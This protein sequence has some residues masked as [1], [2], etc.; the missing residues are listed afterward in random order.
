MGTPTSLNPRKLIFEKLVRLGTLGGRSKMLNL[1][2]ACCKVYISESRNKAALEMIERAAKLFPKARIINKFEDDTYNRVGYTLVSKITPKAA[3]DIS[4]LKEAVFAMVKSAFEVVDLDKHRGSHPRLGVV[5][6]ICFHPLA[7]SSL[8][9]AASIARSLAS[10]I[11]TSLEVPTFLYGAA[12]QR[13]RTLASIRRE[14]G[15]FKPNAHGSIWAVGPNAEHLPLDPDEG[16]NQVDR[17][18]GIVVMGATKWVD[19][20]N[21]PIFSTDISTVQ[22]IAKRVSEMGGGLP[23]VQAVGLAHGKGLTEVACNLLDP[24]LAGGDKVQLEVERL[25]LEKGLVAGTGY[26]TDLSQEKVVNAFLELEP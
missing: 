18:K 13:G 19:N 23:S 12:H 11:G 4:P 26:F 25:A 20:Y 15:Y 17:S 10:E 5:D 14:L 3:S 6:H 22:R 8:E 21:V 2:L 24:S 7:D 9:Q 16:P 1:T